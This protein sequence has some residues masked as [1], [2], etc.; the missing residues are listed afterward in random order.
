MLDLLPLSEILPDQCR[1]TTALAREI[2]ADR[3]AHMVVENSLIQR[4]VGTVD[5]FD[6]KVTRDYLGDD[7]N[8]YW[9]LL[10]DSNALA[11]LV[12][13]TEPAIAKVSPVCLALVLGRE[14]R[15]PYDVTPFARYTSHRLVNAVSGRGAATI[16]ASWPP[17]HGKT[18]LISRRAAEWILINYPDK[19]VAICGYSDTFAAEHGRTARN[20]IQDSP[21]TFGFGIAPDSSAASNWHTTLGGELW[22]AGTRGSATGRGAD[23]LIID[24]PVKDNQSAYSLTEREENWSWYTTTART[25]LQQGGVTCCIQTRW[26]EEDLAGR[27]IANAAPG[28]LEI[29]TFPAICE[30]DTDEIGRRKGEALWPARYPVEALAKTRRDVGPESWMALYQA[31]PL[32]ASKVGRV[33]PAFDPKIHVT[34]VEF[35]RDMKVLVSFDWNV[36]PFCIV[37]AQSEDVTHWRNTTRQ[38]ILTVFDELAIPDT[39]TADA[40][41][42]LGERLLKWAAGNKLQLVVTGDASGSRR[43]T[44]ATNVGG[45]HQIVRDYF[46]RRTSLFRVTY[47]FAKSNT[48]VRES[49]LQVVAMMRTADGRIQFQIDPRC[50]ETIEDLK[51]NRWKRDSNGNFLD[52]IDSS[53]PRRGHAGD[54]LR[55]L[56]RSLRKG[57]NPYGEQPYAL[58][59]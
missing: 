8:R 35:R 49:V 3:V 14:R 30:D 5:Q 26:H 34:E 23:L 33:Y 56:V 50:R 18:T 12:S 37:L 58:L 59:R 17:R 24:D 11:E 38:Y 13:T 39:N 20:D 7:W 40:V 19:S 36:N 22:T 6:D 15:T 45:D 55:Y 9:A 25:R 21:A 47:D 2:R 27:I 57:Q 43:Q 41:D 4:I 42:A 46:N 51:T 31:S 10:Q 53:D 29:I 28:E 16:V 32:G 44:S 54:A 48:S 1:I 52:T